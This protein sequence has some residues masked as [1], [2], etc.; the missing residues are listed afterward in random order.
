MRRAIITP[1]A[2][3]EETF[4]FERW[5]LNT[6][7][8]HILPSKTS[9]S[10]CSDH[11]LAFYSISLPHLPDM[12][13]P[14]NILRIQHSNGSGIEFNALE[15]LKL[16]NDKEDIIKVAVAE[17][18]TESRC[19]ISELISLLLTWFHN[20]LILGVELVL[21]FPTK[22]ATL[23]TGLLQQIILELSLELLLLK[24]LT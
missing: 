14:D 9:T 17:A 11:H 13:F 23:L 21:M 1:P 8:S 16:V 22:S 5:T 10:P 12:V 2:A 6:K 3:V 7:K 20:F 24:Q 19:W 15:A 18:W 4:E